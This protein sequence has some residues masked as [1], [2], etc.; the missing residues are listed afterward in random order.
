M[1][2]GT[3]GFQGYGNTRSLEIP[4]G[5]LA[6]VSPP[7]RARLRYNDITSQVELS[8]SGGAYLPLGTGGSPS[9]LSYA[10]WVDQRSGNDGSAVVG[11]V[12]RPFAT[13]QAAVTAALASGGTEI[14]ILILPGNYQEDVVVPSPSAS[15]SLGF[16]GL[17]G[18]SIVRSITLNGSSVPGTVSSY[19]VTDLTLGNRVGGGQTVSPLVVAV[20]DGDIDVFCTQVQAFCSTSNVDLI[21]TENPSALGFLTL[22]LN[23]GQ[24]IAGPAA[25]NCR[26][27]FLQSGNVLMNGVQ[28]SSNNAPAVEIDGFAVLLDVGSSFLQAGGSS[29]LFTCSPTSLPFLNFFGTTFQL[30]ALNTVVDLPTPVANVNMNCGTV[31]SFVH[32]GAGINTPGQTAINYLTD[33]GGNRLSV[34]SL[35]GVSLLQGAELVAFDSTTVL[36]SGLTAANGID[37]AIQGVSETIPRITGGGTILAGDE[38]IILVDESAAATS[39][40]LPLRANVTNGKKYRIV[41]ATPGGSAGITVGAS[42]GNTIN[43]A[44]PSVVVATGQN[45]YVEVMAE[46]GAPNNWQIVGI[47]P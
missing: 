21:R 46:V 29:P 19:T 25:S 4:N 14:S 47:R 33:L 2:K 32:T 12:A 23:G 37:Q 18:V 36:G 41:D 20:G 15:I 39:V 1:S 38:E 3:V 45:N 16:A 44:G 11:D 22:Q 31:Q 7:D 35:A 8:V 30:F 43:N 42:G 9:A 10:A 17:S 34:T 26:T 6:P 24:A 5:D 27:L 40:F 13:V 28:C